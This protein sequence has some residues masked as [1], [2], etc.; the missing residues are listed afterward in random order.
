MDLKQYIDVKYKGKSDWFLEELNSFS[1]QNKI[2][3]TVAIKEYLN[4]EHKILNRPNFQY[5]GEVVNPRRIVIQLAKTIVN[6]KTQY[7]LKNPV[8]LVGDM[9]MIIEF[10]KVNKLARFDDKNE[11]ILNRL[12]KYGEVYEYLFI[13]KKG[14]IDSKLINADEGTP[15]YNR[16]NELIGFIEHYIFDGISYYTVYSDEMVQ[17]YSNEGANGIRLIGSYVNVTG[18][19]IVYKSEDEL[20]NNQGRSELKDYMNILDNMED[21]MSKYVDSMYKF[22]NPIPVAIGQQLSSSLP[23]EVVG[24]GINLD[25]GADFKMVSNE[26]D[27]KSFQIVYDKLNQ[28]LLDVS[29]TPAVSMNKTDISNLSEVSIKLLFSLADTSAGEYENYLMEGFIERYERIRDILKIQG[30]AIITDEQFVTL[31]FTFIY[32]TPSNNKEILDN[33]KTQFD[34]GAISLDTILEN[35]PYVKDASLERSRIDSQK[36]MQTIIE[37]SVEVVV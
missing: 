4:G 6:F 28:T 26:L 22:M 16:N 37:P 21:V 25:D 32:N 24:H 7:L 27:S 8:T 23:S 13:N 12:I 35:S 29:S 17:E 10:M 34:M 1:N 2:T 36:V 20:I 30:K 19:P 5:N 11:K 14:N 18:L 9:D 15:V 33:M 31:D 3:D